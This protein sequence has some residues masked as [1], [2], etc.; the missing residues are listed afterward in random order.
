[1][2]PE[3]IYSWLEQ[4]ELPSF[5]C[6]LDLQELVDVFVENYDYVKL[7]HLCRP[8]DVEHYYT[9]GIVAGNKK[10]L[11]LSLKKIFDALAFSFDSK[12]IEALDKRE[13]SS[14]GSIYSVFDYRFLLEHGFCGHYGTHGSEQLCA[15]FQSLGYDRE[16][17]TEVG[18]AAVISFIYPLNQLCPMQLQNLVEGIY[19]ADF[20]DS[21]EMKYDVRIDTDI[22][23]EL[24]VDISF[25]D[26]V[27][28]FGR[29]YWQRN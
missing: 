4:P 11:E 9:H 10:S 28:A 8:I 6:G 17:L 26:V 2:H 21:S 29:T 24:I 23:P 14:S 13:Y 27:K 19:E 25:P 7:Y 5:E 20:Y 12:T 22:K 3:R 18:K 15:L 1:M 16:L